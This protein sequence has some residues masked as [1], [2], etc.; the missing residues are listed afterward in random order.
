MHGAPYVAMCVV[1]VCGCDT[2]LPGL[3]AWERP[4]YFGGASQ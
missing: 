3:I 4:E 1:C 2:R